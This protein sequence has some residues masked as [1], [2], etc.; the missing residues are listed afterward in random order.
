GVELNKRKDLFSYPN[1]E[2]GVS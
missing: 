1:P 2:T